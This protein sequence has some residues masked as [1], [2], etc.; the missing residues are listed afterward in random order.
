MVA[1]CGP[2]PAAAEPRGSSQFYP[3]VAVWQPARGR[4]FLRIEPDRAELAP[5]IV[6]ASASARRNSEAHRERVVGPREI[7][8]PAVGEVEGLR[9]ADTPCG[10]GRRSPIT[11]GPTVP[12]LRNHRAGLL[13]QGHRLV[14][15]PR[16]FLRH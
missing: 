6:F 2:A 4:P 8:D 14:E 16:T 7:V 9:R 1:L 5:R 11:P 10:A 13:D 12:T 3:P 15:A